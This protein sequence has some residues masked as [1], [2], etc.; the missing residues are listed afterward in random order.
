MMNALPLRLGQQNQH[1]IEDARKYYV[2]FEN[3]DDGRFYYDHRP[4]T[5]SNRVVLEDLGVT[6]LLN[7]RVGSK[8]AVSIRDADFDIDDLPNVPL[9][10]ADSAQIDLL[11]DKIVSLAQRSGFGASVATKLLHKKRPHLIPVLDNQAIFGA[12]LKRN[13]PSA[14]PSGETVKQRDRILE[15]LLAIKSALQVNA[16][17]LSQLQAENPKRTMIELFDMVWWMYFNEQE[18]RAGRRSREV[19]V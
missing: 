10:D 3:E 13:W 8:A 15:A 18:H 19:R 6:L 2:A 4:T 9:V 16:D 17:S 1:F 11:A 5:Q 14:E 12:Y 7:S